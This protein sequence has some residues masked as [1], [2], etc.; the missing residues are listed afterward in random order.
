VTVDL[1]RVTHVIVGFSSGLLPAIQ[2]LFSPGQVLILE[3][4]D[5]LELRSA[6]V[7]D[8]AVPAIAGF[9]AAPTQDEQGA[10][11]LPAALVRPPR[12]TT[13]ASQARVSARRGCSAIRLN[14]VR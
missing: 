9:I 14:S 4:P 6:D 10:G 3:E 11:L 5:V 13:G 2:R 8:A 7:R 1:S 12:L